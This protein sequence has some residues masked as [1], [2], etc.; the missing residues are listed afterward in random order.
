MQLVK[1]QLTDPAQSPPWWIYVD[2]AAIPRMTEYL[3]YWMTTDKSVSKILE[4]HEHENSRTEQ[5]RGD[6]PA[7]M[8]KMGVSNN[9]YKIGC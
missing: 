6:T 1:T 9:Y 5:L 3:D 4:I 2:E 8:A 7:A